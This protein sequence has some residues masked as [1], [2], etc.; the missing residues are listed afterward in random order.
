LNLRKYGAEVERIKITQNKVQGRDHTWLIFKFNKTRYLNQS[1][2]DG[3]V[4][5]T[6]GA[7]CI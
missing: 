4:Q 2:D 3:K 5:Q 1:T 6:E 7:S